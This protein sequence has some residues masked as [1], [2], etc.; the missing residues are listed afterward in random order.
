MTHI[1]KLVI[2]ASLKTGETTRNSNAKTVSPK[3]LMEKMEEF[4]DFLSEEMD[5]KI[6][7]YHRKNNKR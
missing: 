4:Q 6:A 3:D 2:K 1:G 5:R 7:D